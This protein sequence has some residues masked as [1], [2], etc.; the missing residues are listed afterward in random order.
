MKNNRPPGIGIIEQ[1]TPIIFKSHPHWCVRIETEFAQ[2]YAD[3]F[4]EHR[5]CFMVLPG[6]N[7]WVEVK[8]FL[9]E[10]NC[11]YVQFIATLKDEQQVEWLDNQLKIID[12][13]LKALKEKS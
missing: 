12:Q 10:Q 1:K 3:F 13:V 11:G 4:N 8:E 6:S 5:C 9:S 7:N 2:K